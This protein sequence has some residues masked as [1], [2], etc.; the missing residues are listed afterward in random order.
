MSV[1]DTKLDIFNDASKK[2]GPR[3]AH[4]TTS[5]ETPLDTI[6]IEVCSVRLL[7]ADQ[8]R[9]LTPTNEYVFKAA[10]P[11][12]ALRWVNALRA[13]VIRMRSQQVRSTN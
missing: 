6:Y 3:V 11:N 9:I 13:A 7:T 12:E 2:D 5:T 1:D 10:T 4:A 8:L